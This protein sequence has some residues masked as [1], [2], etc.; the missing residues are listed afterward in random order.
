MTLINVFDSAYYK[1]EIVEFQI[2]QTKDGVLSIPKRM[3]VN[4]PMSFNTVKWG[5]A[6]M[7]NGVY[8]PFYLLLLNS[9]Q[10]NKGGN[11]VTTQAPNNT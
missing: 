5:F 11:Y 10:Y 8:R 6:V 7:R 9:L 3:R 1:V 2:N 4:N